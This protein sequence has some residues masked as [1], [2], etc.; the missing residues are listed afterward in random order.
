MDRKNLTYQSFAC[1]PKQNHRNHLI[2]MH[3]YFLCHRHS[4]IGADLLVFELATTWY[5]Y[6]TPL[7]HLNKSYQERKM[8]KNTSSAFSNKAAISIK[9]VTIA[10]D[11]TPLIG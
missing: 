5:I 10:T 7:N 9:G 6:R 8:D 11:K 1:P 3:P 4:C 2:M